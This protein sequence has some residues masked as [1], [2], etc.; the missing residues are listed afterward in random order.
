MYQFQ[1][2]LERKYTNRRMVELV[3]KCIYVLVNSRC[4]GGDVKEAKE[5]EGLDR[6]NNMIKV[7]E[8][9]IICKVS[10]MKSNKRFTSPEELVALAELVKAVNESPRTIEAFD[11]KESVLVSTT[12]TND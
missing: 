7:L 8:D 1:K 2:F 6:T 3:K 4:D 9:L 11:S 10:E 5:G 12:T